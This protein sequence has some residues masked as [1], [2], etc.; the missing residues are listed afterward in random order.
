MS[1][2]WITWG[3]QFLLVMGV[4]RMWFALDKNTESLTQLRELLAKEYM[5]RDEYERRHGELRE[6]VHELRDKQLQPLVA[7]VATLE[8]RSRLVPILEQVRDRLDK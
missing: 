2:E 1:T 6:S 7:K 4:G 8:E 5:P 3:F